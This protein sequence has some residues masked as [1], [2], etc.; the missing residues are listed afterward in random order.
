MPYIFMLSIAS[1]CSERQRILNI[2]Q[3][4]LGF[5]LQAMATTL[6]STTEIVDR[7]DEADPV[8][9]WEVR[10]YVYRQL[11]AQLRPLLEQIVK[12]ND[13][14]PG[15]PF[16][17]NAQAAARRDLKNHALAL[18]S[19]LEEPEVTEELLKRYER[20]EGGLRGLL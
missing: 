20:G 13:D 2:A 9:A 14:E 16:V 1:A 6:P 3:L 18:M 4:L 10:R 19:F 8:R 17:F 7:I 11:A 12:D 5:L 15:A